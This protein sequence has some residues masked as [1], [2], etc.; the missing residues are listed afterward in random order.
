MGRDPRSSNE[1]RVVVNKVRM[2][3]VGE[4]GSGHRGRRGCGH[5]GKA[6]GQVVDRFQ[7]PPGGGG[8]RRE[9]VLDE[10]DVTDRVVARKGGNAAVVADPPGDSDGGVAADRAAHR[11]AYPMC[12]PCI[13]PQEAVADGMATVVDGHRA[14]PLTGAGHSHDPGDRHHFGGHRPLGG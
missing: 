14:G 1:H 10:Q 13:R 9:V 12:T 8:H 5:A 11:L 4:P 6:H 2:P 7:V 3:V